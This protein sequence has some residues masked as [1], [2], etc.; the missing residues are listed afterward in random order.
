MPTVKVKVRSFVQK[1][2]GELRRQL[3][4]SVSEMPAEAPAC[5]METPVHTS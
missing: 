2:S 3:E 4:I 5:L 1:A